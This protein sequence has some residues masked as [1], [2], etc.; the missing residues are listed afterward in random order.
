VGHGPRTA[1]RGGQTH[2]ARIRTAGEIIAVSGDTDRILGYVDERWRQLT[3]EV[4]T[5]GLLAITGRIP[6]VEIRFARR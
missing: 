6:G 3:S 1:R 5:A 2:G 4:F